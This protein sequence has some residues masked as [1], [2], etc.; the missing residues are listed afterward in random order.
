MEYYCIMVLT[1]EEKNF[2]AQA[3]T[4]L[5]QGGF[6]SSLYFFERKLYTPRRG[7]FLGALFPGYLFLQTPALTPQCMTILRKQKG[8]CRILRDN[9]NPTRLTGDALR[10]LRFLVTNGEILDVSRLQFLAGQKIKVVSGPLAGYEGHIKCVNRKQKRVT[11]RSL[12][13]DGGV[14][15]DLKYEEVAATDD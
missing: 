5:E 3:T 2:K 8:F 4:A 14:T 11:V 13:A 15:F 7:W 12:L 10:E 1:G 6:P 9:Q